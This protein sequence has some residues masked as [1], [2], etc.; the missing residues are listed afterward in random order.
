MRHLAVLSD[1]VVLTTL[2]KL[3]GTTI[4]FE[5]TDWQYGKSSFSHIKGG[6]ESILYL[7]YLVF[8]PS[9]EEKNPVTFSLKH[10]I[11]LLKTGN[12]FLSEEESSMHTE[13]GFNGCV[14]I[15]HSVH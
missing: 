5:H 8:Y 15:H 9:F 13:C 3:D 11:Q 12:I 4:L 7:C 2:S 6:V 1:Q 14:K 10:L